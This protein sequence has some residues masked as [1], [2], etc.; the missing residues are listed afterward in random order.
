MGFGAG[1]SGVV[2]R[3]RKSSVVCFYSLRFFFSS[4]S[5]FCSI[6]MKFGERLFGAVSYILLAMGSLPNVGASEIW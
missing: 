2:G 4:A 3:K 5:F 1:G 6:G